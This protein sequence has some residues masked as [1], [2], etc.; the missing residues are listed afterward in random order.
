MQFLHNSICYNIIFRL[1]YPK[2]TQTV[3]KFIFA[4][5][6]WTLP[7]YNNAYIRISLFFQIYTVVYIYKYPCK[8][9]YLSTLAFIIC[10]A[11]N[12]N[13]KLTAAGKS[14]VFAIGNIFRGTRLAD[15]IFRRLCVIIRRHSLV[16]TCVAVI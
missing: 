3:C 1:N 5:L 9:L 12:S 8:N 11:A 16:F 14:F 4:K 15:V 7:F 10:I 13:T 6:S 2:I